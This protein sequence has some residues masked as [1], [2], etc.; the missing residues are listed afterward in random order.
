[1]KFRNLRRPA[2]AEKAGVT[3]PPPTKKF[4]KASTAAVV[5]PPSVSEEAEYKHHVQF[6]KHSYSSKKW[7]HASMLTLLKQT[8]KQRQRWIDSECPSVKD[9]M[10]NFPCLAEA[11]LVRYCTCTFH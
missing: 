4:K 6:I 11:K 2:R 3:V 8:A 1:M 9:V 7:S 10:T 5:Q